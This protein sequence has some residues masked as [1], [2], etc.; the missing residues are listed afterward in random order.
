MTISGVKTATLWSRQKTWK[1]L[2][3]LKVAPLIQHCNPIILSS[4]T[5]NSRAR[6]I[7]SFH[8]STF[9]CH[10]F[11]NN[12][13]TV[14]FISPNILLTNMSEVGTWSFSTRWNLYNHISSGWISRKKGGSCSVTLTVTWYVTFTKQINKAMLQINASVSNKGHTYRNTT[15]NAIRMEISERKPRSSFCFILFFGMD[16]SPQ[17]TSSFHLVLSWR[18]LKWNMQMEKKVT[19]KIPIKKCFNDS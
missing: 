14:G 16:F 10:I 15:N 18:G 12:K 17:Q 2:K 13:Q 8:F 4:W 7:L 5:V 3:N 9:L 11:K 1:P 6:D 19:L